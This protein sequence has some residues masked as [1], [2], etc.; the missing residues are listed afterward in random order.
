MLKRDNI[1]LSVNEAE[2]K[3]MLLVGKIMSQPPEVH[4]DT[5]YNGIKR[6]RP[7]HLVTILQSKITQVQYWDLASRCN[8][9]LYYKD[10]NEY[11]ERFSELLH[12]GIQLQIG[13]ET[14][15]AAECSGGLDSSSI[16]LAAHHFN[17]SLTLYTHIDQGYDPQSERLRESYFVKQLVQKYGFKHTNIDANNFNLP[18]VFDMATEVLAGQL[19]SIFPLGANIIHSQVAA[20]KSKILLS[21]FGGDECVSGHAYLFVYLPQLVKHGEYKK[22]WQEYHKHY[23]VNHLPKPSAI[24]QAKTWLCAQFPELGEKFA[25][26]RH[27]QRKHNFA[28]LGFSL[29]EYEVRAGSVA[30]FEIRQLICMDN[31][32]PSYRIEDSALIARHYG[33]KYK[34]PLLYPKL[35]EFCNRL[36]LHMK[37]QDGLSRIMIRKYLAQ[38]GMPEFSFKPIAKFDGSIMGST[39]TKMKQTYYNDF[40]NQLNLPLRYLEIKQQILMS[41]P[42]IQDNLKL[43]QDLAL[44][45]LN[46]YLVK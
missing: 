27:Q 1:S 4:E 39:V 11:L 12:E 38:A 31:N 32:H 35:V 34:Y 18:Q 22:A 41:A 13:D 3:Y 30:E 36:P 21:G 8:E 37:R 2:L 10:N 33:F 26:Q 25:L 29:S 23:A 16:I 9:T 20:G 14:A 6:V 43:Y 7:N 42:N 15:I 17:K 28:K 44:L 19:Q 5:L 45:S 40:K 46:Q 24:V